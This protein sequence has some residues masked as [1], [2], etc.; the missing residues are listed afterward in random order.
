[1]NTQSLDIPAFLR[2][3]QQ[4][5]KANWEAFRRAKETGQPSLPPDRGAAGAGQ[6][7]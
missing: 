3:T 7:T 1:M 4:E 5:R 2:L 6:E